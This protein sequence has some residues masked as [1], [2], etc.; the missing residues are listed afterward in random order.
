MRTNGYVDNPLTKRDCERIAEYFTQL[1]N[2]IEAE[3]V[4]QTHGGLVIE[5]ESEPMDL[6]CFDITRVPCGTY[7][8]YLSI[9]S[10]LKFKREV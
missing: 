10:D 3:T 9:T 2:M 4:I 6:N 7:D 8:H 5:A 1:G